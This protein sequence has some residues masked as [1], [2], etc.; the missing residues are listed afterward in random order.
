MR[1]KIFSTL[2]VLALAVPPLAYGLTRS[3]GSGDCCNP[4]SGCCNPPQA[5]CEPGCCE[6]GS[7]CCP[8]P[9]CD[10]QK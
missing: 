2:V 10:A 8:G 6:P 7:P 1:S 3:G 5:C 4:A 9:C